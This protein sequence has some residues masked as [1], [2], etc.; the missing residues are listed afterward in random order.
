MQAVKFSS[1]MVGDTFHLD[2]DWEKTD[3]FMK[4]SEVVLEKGSVRNT[5]LLKESQ[6]HF[7]TGASLRRGA[8]VLMQPDDLVIRTDVEFVLPAVNKPD[9]AQNHENQ[10]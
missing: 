5:V 10:A 1:L 9:E 2:G 3:H 4:T 8:L 6:P 7:F